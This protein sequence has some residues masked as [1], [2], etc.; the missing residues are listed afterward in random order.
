MSGA[1]RYPSRML[2]GM[3]E[4]MTTIKVPKRLRQRISA[5]AARDGVTAAGL[6][7]SLLDERDRAARFE[8]VRAA[9]ARGVDEDYREETRAWDTTL[10]DGRDDNSRAS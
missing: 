2:S 7:S 6:L 1:G 3:P 5:E 4:E 8:A 10:A 9:Y